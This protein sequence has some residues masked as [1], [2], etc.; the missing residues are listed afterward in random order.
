[1]NLLHAAALCPICR[2]MEDEET[3]TRRSWRFKKRWFFGL[4]LIILLLLIA[5]A[6][7][8]RTN[9]ADRLI[10]DELEKRGIRATYVVEEIG[11]RTQRLSNIVLGDP[12]NPDLTASQ[13]E[14]DVAIG[15]KK[16][17]LR[18][19]RGKGIRIQGQLKSDGSLVFGELDK[20]RDTKSKKPFEW[21]DLSV[22]LDDARLSLRT[23][24]GALGAALSGKGQLRRDWQGVLAIHAPKIDGAGCAAQGAHFNGSIHLKE[25]QPILNGP[26]AADYIECKG[27]KFGAQT[28][29]IQGEIRLAERFDRWFGD[30]DFSSK[31]LR[32]GDENFLKTSGLLEFDGAKTRTNFSIKLAEAGYK[33]RTLAVRK[34]S[35]DALGFLAFNDDA[36]AISSRGQ[37][38][39]NGSRADP[40]LLIGL[41]GVVKGT[42]G[43]PIGPIMAAID[44]A[45]RRTIADFD[46]VMN[47]DAQFSGKNGGV[48]I[49]QLRINSRSGTR[50][51]QQGPI[52][53]R[54]GQLAAPL[55]LSLTGGGL[56]DAA[57]SVRSERGGWAGTLALSPYSAGKSRL[58]MP[59][60]A[61]NMARG[62]P[63]RFTGNATLSGPL[64]GGWVEGL[65]LPID[66]TLNGGRF[67]LLNG[68]PQLRFQSFKTGTIA[69]GQQNVRACGVGGPIL[70][71]GGGQT[72][73]A[74]SAPTLTGDVRVGGT[75]IRYFGRNVRFSLADGYT[76]NGVKLDIQLG[77][78]PMRVDMAQLS[79]KVSGNRPFK[80]NTINAV[81][82]RGNSATIF[83]ISSIDGR[84]LPDG[85]AGTLNNGAGRVGAVP[86]NMTGAVG[87]WSYRKSIL[88]FNGG[89]LVSDAAE[90]DRFQPMQVPDL[91]LFMDRGII[92]ANGHLHEPTTGIRVADV[93]VRHQLN[94]AKGR[95]LLSVNGLI[96]NKTFEAK[97]LTELVK[98][99]IADLEGVVS[100]EGAIEWAGGAV[101]S[102]GRFQ[103]SYLDLSAGFGPVKGLSADIRFTNLLGFE[104]APGQEM[105]IKEANPGIPAFD[106]KLR[107]QLLPDQKVS[108]EGGRWP[109]YGGELILEPTIMDFD[110]ASE[111]KLTFKL[112]GLDAEKFLAGY[113][114]ENIRVAGIFDGTLP[115]IFNRDGGRIEGGYL[116]SRDGG[117]EVSYLGELSYQ[118]MGAVANYAFEA[119]R[120]I[121]F[122]QMQIYVDGNLGGEIITRV[123]FDGVQQGSLAKRNFITKKL[124]K[125]PIKFNIRIQAEFLKLISSMRGLYDA[126]YAAQQA[127][128]NLE[129]P[130]IITGEEGYSPPPLKP[131]GELPPLPKGP[132]AEPPLTK[133]NSQ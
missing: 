114:L 20:F 34:I 55:K 91:Q 70:Q 5:I 101:T 63:W 121:Q 99:Q 119:L 41:G 72:R 103:T 48:S 79:G 130:D 39:L 53:Y 82:G 37:A 26:L 14:L 90:I 67:A 102:T 60:L 31:T 126:E 27:I 93:D 110:V 117:G 77:G 17:E 28:P 83:D 43:T 96:F 56:P 6:W 58:D 64:L 21:P 18:A 97:L 11:F 15:F 35:G 52:D 8:Q 107:Y 123:S 105:F 24:N 118:D 73:I 61:F 1:M 85:F 4:L 108:I 86:L 78:S 127:K 133:P 125:L 19:V 7:W 47:Y 3:Q 113:D 33:G 40:G 122:R 111:R 116:V 98:G 46:A 29:K 54:K 36:I 2:K 131:I 45:L 62:A 128:A 23:P 81:I 112:V 22:S 9:L 94:N 66:A 104:T 132:P 25:R 50:I 95:A 84:F 124:A 75:P 76:A 106:G 10:K 115:M 42:A 120:S 88:N 57:L 44:P 65:S 13:V 109:F 30:V 92:T 69:L 87:N 12:A 80:A 49:S 89:L 38:K 71:T 16:P 59:S 51:S 74:F 68:C 129:K 32:Y 100:G